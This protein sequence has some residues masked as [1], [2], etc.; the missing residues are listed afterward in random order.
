MNT[1]RDRGALP[2]TSLV[3]SQQTV[4]VESNTAG[5]SLS[6]MERMKYLNTL[7]IC[8]LSATSASAGETIW[9]FDG[10]SLDGWQTLRGDPVTRGWEIVDGQ[11]HL[12]IGG[13]RDGSIVTDRE[14]GDFELIF[15]WRVAPGGN[16]GI[17]YRVKSFDGK[18]LGCEY[19]LI[20]DTGYRNKL[21]PKHTTG[22]LYDVYEPTG[23]KFL[24]TGEQFNHGRI[25]VRNDH[26]QH[27]LNGQLVMSANVGSAEWMRRIAESKF[28]DVNGFGR[29]QT[30]Q[31]MLT[32][33]NDE[34]WFRYVVLRE[35]G[36]SGVRAIELV[37]SQHTAADLSSTT[38]CVSC[39]GQARRP[40]R[41]FGSRRCR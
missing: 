5:V 8:A 32:D 36:P 31:I 2:P 18:M 13:E 20:D 3:E 28:A 9:L 29:S 17:K 37:R 14:F 38:G 33:H 10:K 35:L 39:C 41:L 23:D 19:Q 27:W 7:L 26:V 11:L 30:G 1:Q 6:T 40:I 24:H 25:V 16:N 22:S 12:A 34:V 21:L 15:E 4:G